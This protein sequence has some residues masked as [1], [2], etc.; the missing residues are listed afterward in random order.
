[1]E[2][3]PIRTEA[4]YVAAMAEIDRLLN[5][6]DGSPEADRLDVLSTLVE[7]F[8]KDRY[9]LPPPDAVAAILYYMDSRGL[10]FSDVQPLLGNEE[11]AAQVLERRRALSLAMIRRL[12]DR[13]GIPADALIRPYRLVRKVKLQG[14]RDH[15][16]RLAGH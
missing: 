9:E 11:I 2:V 8:E 3:R 5:A 1:M 4:D 13:L 15:S 12:H 16:H 14:E 10:S 6:P 7:A